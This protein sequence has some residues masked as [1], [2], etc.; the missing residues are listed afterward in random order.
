MQKIESGNEMVTD[1]QKD[2]RTAPCRNTTVFFFK[3]GV[4]KADN[5][6]KNKN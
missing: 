1:G 4:S 2:G 5:I 3:M 6:F